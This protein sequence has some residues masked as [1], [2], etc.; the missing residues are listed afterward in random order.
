M[1]CKGGGDGGL[2]VVVGEVEGW[3]NGNE[4]G[5]GGRRRGEARKG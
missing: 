2:G 5:G 3:K 4:K 1:G